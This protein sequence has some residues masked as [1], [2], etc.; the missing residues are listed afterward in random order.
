MALC[1]VNTDSAYEN[2]ITEE[3]AIEFLQ[4]DKEGFAETAKDFL[5]G[6]EF[7]GVGDKMCLAKL[8]F[9]KNQIAYDMA[10]N[11]L[12]N[13][14]KWILCSERLPEELDDYTSDNV[15]ITVAE[16]EENAARFVFVGY[17]D[18]REKQWYSCAECFHQHINS[19]DVIAWKPGEKPYCNA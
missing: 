4:Q 15:L 6:A 5:S 9:K 3:Q 10:I 14:E 11:A 17:Y 13:K 16:K 19:Y 18:Y 8:F 2:E 7:M 12:K 1:F